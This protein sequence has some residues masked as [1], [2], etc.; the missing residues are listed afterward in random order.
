MIRESAKTMRKFDVI[1]VGG[2]IM[3]LSHAYHSLKMGLKV[4]VV[5]KSVYPQ[6]ASVRNF[7]QIVPSG[8]ASKWQRYGRES[9]EIYKELQDKVDLTIR[10]EGST[11]IASND[12]E[13]SLIE[14]LH[15]IN[16]VNCYESIL[17]TKE[18]CLDHLPHLNNSYPKAGLYFP[19]EM[20]IDP[21]TGIRRLIDYLVEAEGLTYISST[22][23]ESAVKTNGHII[24][25]STNGQAN[26]CQKLIICSGNEF[27]LLFSDLFM[28][29]GIVQVKLQMM[30][31]V[32]QKMVKVKGS[33]LTGWTIRRY[34]CFS[35]CMS[36]ERIK[37]LENPK[38]Y[39]NE[40]GIHILLK[41]N[42]D[43]TIIIGDSHHYLDVYEDH[44]MDFKSDNGVNCFM[45]SEA[46]KIFDLD[47]WEIKSTWNGYYCQCNDRDIYNETIDS[48]I[49]I[50]T[51]IG[52][53]GMT[54]SLGYAKENVAN[55]FSKNIISY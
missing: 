36:F 23:I 49:H 14:E 10:Q 12:D 55:I 6:A 18:R 7:G 42:L 35:E 24:T 9:L 39:H 11:Y 4:A 47:T 1:I 40:N 5:E 27:Q 38:S 29:S 20:T 53:K 51:A 32:P 25:R 33:L 28:N 21:I 34:E 15:E 13:L 54:A 22:A 3:G 48:D 19:Q 31:T 2:G 45:L 37:S 44:E 41:Q 16:R 17:L 30:E 26:A 43:K 50:V 52:G 46:L 8:F